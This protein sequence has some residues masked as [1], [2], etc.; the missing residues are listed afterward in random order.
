MPG[1]PGLGFPGLA[2]N[3]LIPTQPRAQPCGPPHFCQSAWSHKLEV[4]ISYKLEQKHF[5]RNQFDPG[6]L[7]SP[8][9]LV[10]HERTQGCTK[11]EGL[12][13]GGQKAEQITGQH[14]SPTVWHLSQDVCGLQVLYLLGS[15]TIAMSLQMSRQ[16]LW[17]TLGPSLFAMVIMVTMWVSMGPNNASVQSARAPL[18]PHQEERKPV[19]YLGGGEAGSLGGSV[20]RSALTLA[21][22]CPFQAAQLQQVL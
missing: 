5:D 6:T 13:R 16:G 7:G 3:T 9:P 10:V 21:L 15:L 20:L 1:N 8:A 19:L 17:N 12:D 11:T 22:C 4:G 14:L 18:A 2:D